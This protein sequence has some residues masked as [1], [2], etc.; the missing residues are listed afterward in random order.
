MRRLTSINEIIA[1]IHENLDA[2]N[3][4]KHDIYEKSILAPRKLDSEF[5]LKIKKYL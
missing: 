2:L 1:Y 4:K 3:A 5:K